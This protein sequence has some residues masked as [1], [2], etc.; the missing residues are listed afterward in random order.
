[1]DAKNLSGAAWRKDRVKVIDFTPPAWH[2]VVAEMVDAFNAILPERAPRL[3]H[4]P[5]RERPCRGAKKDARKGVVVLCPRDGESSD[6]AYGQE[7]HTIT[8]AV[9]SIGQWEGQ[10]PIWLRNAICHELMHAV[11]GIPDRDQH[12]YLD[13]CVWNHTA[14]GPG[15]LDRDYAKRVYKKYGG[16]EKKH[17]PH[18]R[19]Q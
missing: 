8:D 9:V 10:N 1:M 11:T 16:K 18:H 7:R 6:A 19:H 14:T 13:S 4:V 3:I 12:A 15:D 17:K 2:P 5:M